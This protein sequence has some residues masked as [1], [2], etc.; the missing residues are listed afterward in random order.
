VKLYRVSVDYTIDLVIAAEDPPT[1]ADIDSAAEDEIEQNGIS[2]GMASTPTMITHPG[3][4][5]TGWA[6]AV[7]R[8]DHDDPRTCSQ[9]IDE[10]PGI[11]LEPFGEQLTL[12]RG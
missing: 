5:P 3:Q 10:K 12:P 4:I 8:G 1:W 11:L 9:L 7:P 2:G 6:H